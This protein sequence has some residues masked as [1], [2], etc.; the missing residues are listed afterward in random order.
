VGSL[1]DVQLRQS[2]PWV[3]GDD[4]PDLDTMAR[5]L[6]AGLVREHAMSKRIGIVEPSDQRDER[7]VNRVLV[8]ALKA[9]GGKVLD[10]YAGQDDLEHATAESASAVLRFNSDHVDTVIPFD[11]GPAWGVLGLEADQ[12]HFYPRWVLDS[13]GRPQWVLDATPQSGEP[14]PPPSTERNAIA[15]GYAPAYDVLD[16]DYP[17]FPAEQH[18]LVVVNTA[19]GTAL[20]HRT[21]GQGA[22]PLV[23]CRELALLRQALSPFAGRPIAAAELA[24]AVQALGRRYVPLDMPRSSFAPGKPDGIAVYRTSRY[25]PACQ[26]M[27]YDSPWTPVPST[28]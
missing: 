15:V 12:Q 25:V 14:P 4:S 23:A 11:L 10:V 2:A 28:R 5:L 9:A 21:Y 1:D 8:P 27:R 18:C 6:V 22:G 19:L 24:A 20:S 26:C 13:S 3:I 7:V 16:S 17:L